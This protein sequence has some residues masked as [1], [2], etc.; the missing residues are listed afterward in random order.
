MIAAPSVGG[1]AG[2]V[3]Q[4]I[5]HRLQIDKP[6]APLREQTWT[7]SCGC[8]TGSVPAVGAFGV[9]TTKGRIATANA[10]FSRHARYALRK[11]IGTP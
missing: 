7:C 6:L 8:W 3:G 10:A 4:T 11:V 1:F 5:D 2:R 9:T